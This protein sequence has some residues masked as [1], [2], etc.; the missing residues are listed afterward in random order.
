MRYA[1]R[2]PATRAP[3]SMSI[4]V[5]RQLEVV[6]ARSEANLADLAQRRVLVRGRRVRRVRKRGQR[7]LQ[8]GLGAG[9]LLPER[10]HAR[11]DLL[12]RGDLV[13]GVATG[14]LGLSDRLRRLVLARPQA[15]GLR[16][17]RAHALVELERAIEPRVGPV[18]PPR[19]RL[20]HR[21]R[22]A[23]DLLE[24]EHQRRSRLVDVLV[25]LGALRARRSRARRAARREPS[26]EYFATNSATFCASSP[27]TMF[28]GIGPEE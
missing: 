22:I 3:A 8:V 14:L 26:P 10:L 21:G 20:A 2:E 25:G 12:H 28:C 6:A 18:T 16:P 24:I 11:R 1:K 9:Q 13:R 19:E 17:Q 5:A 15:L 27:V 23:A 4:M 7:L